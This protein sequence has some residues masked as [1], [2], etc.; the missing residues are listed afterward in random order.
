MSEVVIYFGAVPT[1]FWLSDAGDA[2]NR[3]GSARK[4]DGRYVRQGEAAMRAGA[5][6]RSGVTWGTCGRY[7]AC[8]RLF[9]E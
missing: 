3:E 6:C 9:D 1:T 4:R 7:S 5:G 8:R 2:N